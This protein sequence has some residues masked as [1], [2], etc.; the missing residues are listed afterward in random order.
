MIIINH[1]NRLHHIG[2]FVKLGPGVNTVDPEKWV[3]AKKIKTIR[4]YVSEGILE[5]RH[6]NSLKEMKPD[7]AIKLVKMTVDMAV[8]DKWTGTSGVKRVEDAVKAQ[9][10]MLKNASEEAASQNK[11]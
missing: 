7:A 3:E 5:E 6:E 1:E 9:K 10:T 4:Y 11:D 8:L 2:D